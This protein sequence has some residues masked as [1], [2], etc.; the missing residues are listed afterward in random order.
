MGGPIS[1]SEAYHL[2]LLTEIAYY[3]RR[4]PTPGASTGLLTS[5]NFS[6]AQV[7]A[8]LENTEYRERLARDALDAVGVTGG[9]I[10]TAYDAIQR[11]TLVA[12]FSVALENRS[13]YLYASPKLS[14]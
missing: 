13:Y 1:I 7:L 10:G 2:S 3:N 8:A 4:N 12:P 11:G 9:M 5:D 6:N 14:T